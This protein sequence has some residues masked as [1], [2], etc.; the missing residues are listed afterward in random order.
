M[1]GLQSH[2][3]IRGR[4]KLALAMAYGQIDPIDPFRENTSGL[5]I[6]FKGHPIVTEIAAIII[7]Q[8]YGAGLVV[9]V[10]AG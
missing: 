4:V 5:G 9:T 6:H 2:Q 8:R 10:E 1:V 3:H 7:G